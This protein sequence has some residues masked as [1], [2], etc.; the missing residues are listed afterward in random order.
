MNKIVII[1]AGK[2]GTSI[3]YALSKNTDNSITLCDTDKVRIED[4]NKNNCNS[5]IF[6]NKKLNKNIQ[7]TTETE[8]AVQKA[9]VI[10]SAVP[11]IAIQKVSEII[12]KNRQAGSIL[13]NTSKGSATKDKLTTPSEI[14][15]KSANELEYYTLSGPNFAD[16]IIKDA[17]SISTLSGKGN[18]DKILEILENPIIKIEKNKENAM[19]VELCGILKNALAIG[20]GMSDEFEANTK[21]AILAQGIKEIQFILTGESFTEK[22]I[23]TSAGIGDII[24]TAQ[25]EQSRNYRFG[26]VFNKNK[27]VNKTLK[28][29]DSTVEGLNTIETLQLFTQEKKIELPLFEAIYNI[30]YNEADQ[31]CIKKAIGQNPKTN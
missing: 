30:I 1:G 4:I 16:D 5:T 10:I 22:T 20:S 19:G 24:L 23:L 15:T 14:F 31:S 13:I 8:E 25:S 21:I 12:E 11:A 7:A 27:D 18:S 29:I 9:D 26:K 2:F 3:A 28:I 17:I 6:P